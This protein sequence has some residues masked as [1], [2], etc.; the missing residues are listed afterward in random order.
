MLYTTPPLVP[1][2]CL[3]NTHPPMSDYLYVSVSVS[4]QRCMCPLLS[5]AAYSNTSPDGA[6]EGPGLGPACVAV[7]LISVVKA[8]VLPCLHFEMSIF[9]CFQHQPLSFTTAALQLV[10]ASQYSTHCSVVISWE[11]E[12]E[13]GRQKMWQK[14]NRGFQ[15]V[16]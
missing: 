7:G 5:V 10:S 9:A 15:N 2:S 3:V 13:G 8:D 4:G 14:N 1:S 12:R 16:T 11:G 6:G